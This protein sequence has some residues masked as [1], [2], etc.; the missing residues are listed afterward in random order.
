MRSGGCNIQQSLTPEATTIVKQAINLA[1]RRGHAQ[2]TPIHVAS[3]ML[4]SP[5]GLLR[6]ACLKSNSHPLQCKAL[7]L[8]FN[9]ALNR[10][11]TTSPAPILGPHSHY[12]ALANALMAAFKRAQAHQRRG[13]IETQQQP[14]LALKIETEQLVISILD[15]PSVSRVMREAGFSST[16][17]KSN[18]DHALSALEASTHTTTTSNN[19]NNNSNNFSN[20]KKENVVNPIIFRSVQNYQ[21]QV[22][23][24]LGQFELAF[25]K[26][27]SQSRRDDVSGVVDSWVKRREK[28][29]VVLVGEC[30]ESCEDVVRGVKERVE[31]GDVPLELRYVQ[32]L[33]CPLLSMKNMSREEIDLKLGEVRCFLKGCVGRGVVLYLGDLRW[34]AEYWAYYGEQRRHYYCPVE[35][36]VM[37]LRR[38]VFGNVE[39]GRLWLMGVATFSSYIKCKSGNPSLENLLDLHPLTIPAASLDLTLKLDSSLQDQS[40]S[41]GSGNSWGAQD[42]NTVEMQLT[43]CLDCSANCRQEARSLAGSIRNNESTT[44]TPTTSTSSSLPSW[45]QKYKDESRESSPIN[46]DQ[47]DSVEIKELCRKWNTICSS[48]HKGTNFGDKTINF[49]S[50]SPSSSTSI[51]SYEN[52]NLHLQDKIPSWPIMFEPKWSSKEHQFMSSNPPKD[53][54]ENDPPK[55]ELLSN[56]NSI[57][58]STSSSEATEGIFENPNKFSFKENT[59]ENLELLCS[60]LEGKVPWQKDIIPEIATTIL[61]IRSGIT[62]RKCNSNYKEKELEKQETWLFF[63]GM[64]DEGKQ[65]V[66]RELAKIIFGS[67]KSFKSIGLSSFSSTRADSNDEFTNKRVR[68]ESGRGYLERFTDLV[69]EN[70]HRVLFMEDIDQ[71][72]QF[73][74]KGITRAIETGR[75]RGSDGESVSLEDSIVIFSCDTFSSGSR[76]CSPPVKHKGT[77]NEVDDLEEC[78]SFGPLDLNL[79]AEYD[80]GSQD[81]VADF[82]I[83]ESVDKQVF[84]KIDQ[85]L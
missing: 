39:F 55:P 8:C 67:Y 2:V 11:P 72:D 51:S 73:S 23:P 76:A 31:R 37:G 53:L 85:V 28:S 6:A 21:T 74:L 79:S 59:P 16:H 49:S 35:H 54:F 15:D 78:T 82:S 41:L 40:K 64:D 14:I 5:A 71:V 61:G 70:P 65:K 22:I 42:E 56:P 34:V 27:I 48:K 63:L 4:A 9:V 46:N 18:V 84:F 26:P 81:Y 50:C 83:L 10:L 7:E 77:N 25:S 45:L 38:L 1:R 12:P 69:R 60:A 17:V 47:N 3:V 32:F 24:S 30:L 62:S 13:S 19:N 44:T 75:I 20:I 57:P 68:D 80:Y 52:N 66:G 36:L 58:N 29:S 33:N 43:C